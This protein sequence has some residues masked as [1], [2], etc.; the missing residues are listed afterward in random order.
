[1][2][3]EGVGANA[4]SR[5]PQLGR[6]ILGGADHQGAVGRKLHGRDPLAVAPQRV[7]ALAVRRAPHIRRAVAGA[8]GQPRAVRRE[9]HRASGEPV[10][11]DRKDALSRE[12][13]PDHQ[14]PVVVADGDMRAAGREGHH[15]VAGAVALQGPHLLAGICVAELDAAGRGSNGHQRAVRRELRAHDIAVVP[16]ELVVA[17]AGADAPKP[18]SAVDGCGQQLESAHRVDEQL[19]ERAVASAERTEG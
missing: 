2:A 11:R 6:A 14:P 7:Q 16:L 4:R 1:M 19:Q 5:V 9:G 8:R 15:A 17:V 18:C 13:I 12:R 10:R 3:R